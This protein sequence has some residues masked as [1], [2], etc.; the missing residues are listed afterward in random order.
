MNA[1]TENSRIAGWGRSTALTRSKEKVE[2]VVKWLAWFD[3][4]DRFTLADML[5]VH[6]DGQL[7]FFKR[8]EA[9]GFVVVER[10]PGI[11]RQ[12]YSLGEAGYE[13]AQMVVPELNLKRRRRLPSW[14]TMVHS[15]SVQAA[16]IKRR[17]DLVG[18]TP[19]KSLKHLRTVR[20]PDAIMTTTDGAVIALEVEL[21]HKASARVYNIF[22][23]HLKNVR[24]GHYEK[25]LYLFPNETL[26]RLYQEKYDQPVWPI[27]RALP[28]SS[29]LVQDRDKSFTA[30]PAHDGGVIH[31]AVEDMYRL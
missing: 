16:L 4:S 31:F 17:S 20:L 1:V 5:G 3:Y 12:V 21:S 13:Y 28:G 18:F 27:Y 6:V 2:A 30:R 10:A 15:F 22:L 19:E 26:C 14:V 11:N 23:S 7:A 9:S 24:S 29:K 25:V 8:L